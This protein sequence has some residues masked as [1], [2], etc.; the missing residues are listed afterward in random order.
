MVVA[1]WLPGSDLAMQTPAR[2]SRRLVMAI[3]YARRSHGAAGLYLLW[4][5]AARCEQAGVSGNLPGAV[6]EATN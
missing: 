2:K 6:L 4:R 3:A 1:V 5:R